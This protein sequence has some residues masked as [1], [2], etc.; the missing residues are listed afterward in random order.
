MSN[1]HDNTVDHFAIENKALDIL[2]R[3]NISEPVV[4]VVKIAKDMGIS[5][6]EI[7]MPENYSNVAAFYDQTKK[8][9]YVEMNDK[10]S[11]KLFSVAHELGHIILAHKTREVLFRIPIDGANYLK[12]EKEANSFAA[13]LLMPE[14]MLKEY[15]EKYNLTK[16]DYVKMSEIFGVPVAAM[17]GALDRLQQ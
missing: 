14:F 5:V 12:T 8:T 17:R 7:S 11:R 1:L 4:D 15:L 3:Y 16:G 2:D 6:K 13:N 10:P 9:I